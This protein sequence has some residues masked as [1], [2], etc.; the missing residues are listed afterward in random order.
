MGI[1]CGSNQPLICLFMQFQRSFDESWLLQFV[2]P[3]VLVSHI[4]VNH[5]QLGGNGGPDR[6]TTL[7]ICVMSGWS[8]LK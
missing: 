3:R 5:L 8:P 2:P 7:L 1:L 6:A 4:G